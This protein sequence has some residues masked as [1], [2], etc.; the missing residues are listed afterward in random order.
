MATPRRVGVVEDPRYRDHVGPDGHPERPER[1]HA[2]GDALAARRDA[3]T[4][5]IIATLDREWPGIAGAVKART[6]START[7]QGYLNTPDGA[8]YG[9][10]LRAPAEMP[11][12]PPQNF[13][14][15]VPGLWLASAYSGF[16]GFTGAVSGGVGAAKAALRAAD[17]AL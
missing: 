13:E 12:G 1:L 6:M 8:I 17:G 16:G 9:F 2:V 4:D 7:F 10:A 3:W 5:T 15:A 11:K 14:T